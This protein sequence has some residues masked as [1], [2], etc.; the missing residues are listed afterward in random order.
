MVVDTLPKALINMAKKKPQSIAMRQKV[1]GLWEDITWNDYLNKVECVALALK[2]FGLKK[3]DKA[4]IIGENQP[5]WLYSALGI[6]SV[7]G[8]L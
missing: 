1:Y 2:A 4:A 5:E 6:M 8:I 7:G 3:G